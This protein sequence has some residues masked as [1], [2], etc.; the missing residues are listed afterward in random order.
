MIH[1]IKLYQRKILLGALISA[2]FA[3]SLVVQYGL[4]LGLE[5]TGGVEIEI[6]LE[7]PEPIDRIIRLIPWPK[8]TVSTFGSSS[9]FLIKLKHEHDLDEKAVKKELISLLAE[10]GIH[11]E[12]KRIDIVGSEFS[13]SMIDQSFTALSMALL[14]ITLYI[15]LRFEIRLAVSALLALLF[16]PII[17]LGSFAF[18]QW[19]FDAPTLAGLL[20]VIGYSINDTI[21]V[22]DRVR[23]NFQQLDVDSETVFFTS[24]DQ[25]LGRTLITSL[26]TLMV[27]V[28]LLIFGTEILRGFS[29]ALVIGIVVGTCSSIIVAGPLALLL[30]IKKEHLFPPED[31]DNDHEVFIE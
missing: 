5:F 11:G 30:G 21:V 22:F 25:T 2:L 24:I 1:W 17:I 12:I 18:F 29:L 28:A 26:L 23:E 9:Q 14:A 10:Q 16:D 3:V 7:Q 8:A 15:A 13:T 4:N 31:Q 19:T 6:A 27:V 20:A